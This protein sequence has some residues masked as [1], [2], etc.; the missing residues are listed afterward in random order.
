MTTLQTD[1]ACDGRLKRIGRAYSVALLRPGHTVVF[2][3]AAPRRKRNSPSP[4]SR[5]KVDA[6]MRL[7]GPGELRTALR[8]SS[9]RCAPIVGDRL[10]V[11]V[12]NAGISKRHASR[13]RG[14]GFLTTSLRQTSEARSSWYS[15]CCQFLVRAQTSLLSLLSEP[16][17]WWASPVWKTF[18]SCLRLYQRSTLRLWSRTG[19]YSRSERHTC[20]RCRTRRND[21][22]MSSFTK[23]E[24]GRES[25]WGCRR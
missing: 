2:T 4:R 14:R 11:V 21:T 7:G 15:T 13:L 24:A 20:K 16:V 1:C 19:G 25:R 10:D 17:W 8:C 3:M 6:Q 22:D 5:R 9:N 18:D 23:T 12:L